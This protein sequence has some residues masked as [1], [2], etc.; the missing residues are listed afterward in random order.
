VNIESSDLSLKDVRL[1][2]RI[3]RDRC[4]RGLLRCR[5]EYDHR[6]VV[7]CTCVFHPEEAR[8]CGHLIGDACLKQPPIEVT[9]LHP[10]VVDL[11]KCIQPSAP[12]SKWLSVAV[13]DEEVSELGIE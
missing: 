2:C 1:H 12:L 8:G 10:G 11:A 3:L 6:N 4:A 7:P 5:V 13:I 9:V